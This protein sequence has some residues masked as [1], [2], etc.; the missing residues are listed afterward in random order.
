M[1]KICLFQLDPSASFKDALF[2]AQNFVWTSFT[3]SDTKEVESELLKKT[4]RIQPFTEV[5]KQAVEVATKHGFLLSNMT[6]PVVKKIAEDLHR[7]VRFCFP[8]TYF[9]CVNYCHFQPSRVHLLL[10]SCLVPVLLTECDLNQNY[11]W[12]KIILIQS[13][14]LPI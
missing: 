14:Q 1:N 11:A 9:K 5:S 7:R 8:L 4:E 2:A 3:T 10:C 13:K 6:E 12:R